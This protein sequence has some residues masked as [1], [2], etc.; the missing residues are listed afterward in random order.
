MTPKV[1]ASSSETLASVKTRQTPPTRVQR[2]HRWHARL[3]AHVRTMAVF[4][5]SRARIV[6]SGKMG[7]MD[8]MCICI[9]SGCRG[10]RSSPR[11]LIIRG[12]KGGPCHKIPEWIDFL[13]GYPLSASTTTAV[14]RNRLAE[15]PI[16]GGRRGGEGPVVDAAPVRAVVPGQEAEHHVRVDDSAAVRHAADR[17]RFRGSQCRTPA[18]P[19]GSNGSGSGAGRT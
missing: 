1:G 18:A 2:V 4:P 11:M 8:R 7:G 14:L 17:A 9:H 5:S 12:S 19:P 3:S 6:V 13:S 10:Y 16:L 15:G